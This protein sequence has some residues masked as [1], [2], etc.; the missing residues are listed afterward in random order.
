MEKRALE[1]HRTFRT[2]S[3]HRFL[4]V[5]EAVMVRIFLRICSFGG[6]EEGRR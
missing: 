2:D 5:A 3:E 4:L 1:R 6:E